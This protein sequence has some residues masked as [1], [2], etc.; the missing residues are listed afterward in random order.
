[1]DTSET[2]IKMC[3]CYEVAENCYLKDGDFLTNTKWTHRIS[4]NGIRCE[5]DTDDIWLPRQDQIQEMIGYDQP[6]LLDEFYKFTQRRHPTF[7]NYAVSMGSMEQ[8]WLLFYMFENHQKIWDGKKW[9]KSVK[10]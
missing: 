10:E 7:A 2:Y 1:M 3:D 8:L 9:V 5:M 4:I 6:L